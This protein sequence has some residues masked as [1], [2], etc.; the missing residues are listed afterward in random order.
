MIKRHKFVS[1]YAN[2]NNKIYLEKLAIELEQ[3]VDD[4]LIKAENIIYM[5]NDDDLD[6]SNTTEITD[7]K[8]VNNIHNDENVLDNGSGR[9]GGSN[10]LKYAIWNDIITH[11]NG[12]SAN[13][14]PI[15]NKTLDFTVDG[16]L[17]IYLPEH[18]NKN[19]AKLLV[20]KYLGPQNLNNLTTKE[21]DLYGFWGTI[22]QLNGTVLYNSNAVKLYW[23]SE[24]YK[25]KIIF[26][27][28]I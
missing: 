6:F 28:N 7:I 27:L 15:L 26:K 14:E 2:L 9:S 18:T 12:S 5:I 23:D 19:A 8:Y 3:Y 24:L 13:D 4:Q 20:D 16:E 17:I 10:N 11:A 21:Q 22:P 1:N 25:F